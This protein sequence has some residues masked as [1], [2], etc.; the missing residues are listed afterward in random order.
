MHFGL[1]VFRGV[2]LIRGEAPIRGRHLFQCGHQEVRRLFESRRL[3]EEIRY[4]ACFLYIQPEKIQN[5][6]CAYF[7]KVGEKHTFMKKPSFP[8]KNSFL[9]LSK[10]KEFL[11]KAF[12]ID[13]LQKTF[14]CACFFIIFQNRTHYRLKGRW[15]T[16]TKM[17]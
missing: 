1:A 13:V 10:S 7:Q 5:I 16:T 17:N 9:K 6:L 14:L 4:A 8:N 3:F 15:Q 2:V 11:A 12:F